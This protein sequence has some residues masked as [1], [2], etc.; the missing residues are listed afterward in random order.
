[1]AAP[2][3]EA[4]PVAYTPV[5]TDLWRLVRA[6]FTPRAV[7]EEQADAPTFWMPWL[8]I[9]V[10]FALLQILQRP[11]QMRVR[12]LVLQKLG[13]PIPP[14]GF[15]ALRTLIGFGG[16]GLTVLILACVTAGIFYIL[17][18]V[19]GGQVT[20][21]KMLTVTIF[22]WPIAI[23]QQVLTYIVLSVRGVDAIQSVWDAQASFGADL[24]LPSDMALSPFVRLLLAG[25]GP[26][27]IW[28]VAI[29]AIGLKTLGKVSWGAAWT[30]AIVS[31]LILLFGL[32]FLGSLGMKAAGG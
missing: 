6:P 17:T 22:A 3:P 10:V 2:A 4:K 23:L 32:A 29:T 13:Q 24:L 8:V 11:F 30:V 31:A 21:K 7:F 15:S 14:G 20:F 12:D 28:Q 9:F 5:V 26:L 25:I 1:M 18:M 19:F 27:A 16:T